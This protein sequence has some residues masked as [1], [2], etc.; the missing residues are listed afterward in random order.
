MDLTPTSFYNYYHPDPLRVVTAGEQFRVTKKRKRVPINCSLCRIR[1]NC[2][3]QG[4]TETTTCVYSAPVT[5]EIENIQADSN[6]EAL[7]HRLDRLENLVLTLMR[8]EAVVDARSA[9]ATTN[10]GS[11]S[12]ADNVES[13]TGAHRGQTPEN[14]RTEDDN[15]DDLATSL[16]VLS[17]EPKNGNTVYIGQE[18][19][20]TILTDI[21]ELK[22]SSARYEQE[23]GASY[24]KI[25]LSKPLS[26]TAGI[27]LLQGTAPPAT[28]FELQAA[29]PSRIVILTLCS[30][31]FESIDNPVV[32][33]HPGAF[34]EELFS[35]W[36]NPSKTSP[37][38]LGLLYSILCLGMLSYHRVG[39]E[40]TAWKGRTMEMAVSFRLRT[41]QCLL[42]ADYTKPITPVVETMLLY[43][44]AEYATRWDADMELW[45]LI[46]MVTRIA[47]QMGYHRDGKWFP[48]LNP[49]KAEMRRRTWALLTMADVM[50]SHQVS[51]PGMI[52]NHYCDTVEP[53]NLSQDE[54][55]PN[56]E[57]LPPSRPKDE[58]TP[59]S[60]MIA[61]V[62]LCRVMSDILHATNRV[63]G[64]AYEDILR[65]DTRLRQT[66]DD[67]PEHLRGPPLQDPQETAREIMTRFSINSLYRKIVCLLHKKHLSFGRRNSRYAYSRRSAVGAA[68]E[69]L[70]H[71]A[72]LIRESQPGG[73]FQT[74]IWFLKSMATK[75]FLTCAM[76][77]A[78]DLYHDCKVEDM[79]LQSMSDASSFWTSEQ[80]IKMINNLEMT[81]NFWKSL[82]DNS[83]EA[84]RASKM[85]EII[86]AQINRTGMG[87][88]HN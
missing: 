72:V 42:V 88:R 41:V 71:L 47:I 7:Q 83:K 20:Q 10:T 26:A 1:N 27:T 45:L 55:S 74:L 54:I 81:K 65:L 4:G 64:T 34:Y 68:S 84:L 2:I 73:R 46:S 82:A 80:T 22:A 31:Y 5:S 24:E 29:L 60:Y 13:S 21:L 85:L 52:H 16:G 17:I 36:E 9:S 69:T 87:I 6:T 11:T 67:I 25:R 62:K 50:F 61:K 3:R 30:R 15:I 39:D 79:N 33:V 43:T 23:L 49:F 77:V 76:I 51:L 63:D 14:I 75:E 48:C 57:F 66:Y 28:E 53:A 70:E 59:A 56:L 40:P 32:I 86:L 35:H 18:H 19:W 58:L 37:M 12:K 44:F 38:W 8:G 78:R